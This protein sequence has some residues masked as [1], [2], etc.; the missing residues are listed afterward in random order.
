MLRKLFLHVQPAV[1]QD[2]LRPFLRGEQLN[3]LW[4]YFLHKRPKMLCE[5]RVLRTK[6]DLQRRTVPSIANVIQPFEERLPR[7]TRVSSGVLSRLVCFSLISIALGYAVFNQ[8][9]QP[10]LAWNTSLLIIG[11]GAVF[12]TLAVSRADRRA[13]G[14]LVGWS[15]LLPPAYVGFQ[16]LP[17]PLPV[18]RI[19]SPARAKLIDSLIPITQPPAL[20][21]ISI[22]PAAT[23]V[24][25]LRTLAYSLTVLLI[26]ETSWRWLRRHS[27]APVVPLIVVAAFEGCL[28][29]LQF[30]NGADVAGTYRSHDHFA[31][32][33]EMVLPLTLAY[34]IFLLRKPD[35]AE[36][37]PASNAVKSCIAF[38]CAAVM[39]VGLVYSLSK[40]G[41]LAGLGGLFAIGVLA[42]LSKLKGMVRWFA[43]AGLTVLIALVFVFLPTDQLANAYAGYFSTDPTSMEGRAPIWNDS[44]QLLRAYPAVGTG[45]GTYETAFLK[46]QTAS[47]DWNYTFAHNDYLQLASELGAVGFLIFG[48]LFL[49]VLLKTVRAAF[50]ED[51]NTRLLGLGCVG[52]LTAIGIHSLA[53]FN[54]YI[55]ANALLLS[56]IVGVAISIPSLA[57][58]T[59]SN[60]GARER[61]S[62]RVKVFQSWSRAA[63]RAGPIALGSVLVVYATAW[64]VF[65]TTY[66][67]DPGAER[68]FCN[69]GICGDNIVYAA[70]A[71][72][73]ATPAIV[74]LTNFVEDVKRD[75]AAPH[76]WCDL[77]D[78]F[79][80]AGRLNE[81]RYCFSQAVGL[82][83]EIPPVLLRSANFYHAV[84]DDER[85]LQR[86]A[87]V[88]DKSDVYQS[89]ILDFYRDSGFSV[90]DILSRGLPPGPRAAQTYL[91]YWIQ[92]GDLGK[93]KIAW[94]WTLAHHDADVPTARDYLN[95]LYGN[96]KYQDAA[97]A[98]VRFLGDRRSDYREVNW[99]Y[100]GDFETE[101]SGVPLDWQIARADGPA[102]TT[103][104]SGQSHTG[105]HSLRIRF[106]G[107]ENVNY[108]DTVQK[109]SVPHGT[110]RFSAYIR[111]QGITT[112]KGVAFRIFDAEDSTNL[113]ART[114]Q[115]VGTTP[116]WTRVERTVRVPAATKLLEVQVIREPTLKFD[117]RVSGTAWID[118][119]SLS[120]IE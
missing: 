20:A 81:A 60:N 113:N 44:R 59:R 50:S 48:G 45:L 118:T 10:S 73:S 7:A 11:A 63:L 49:I 110:Y 31:G 67:G 86:G 14:T 108:S 71:T 16:L 41:F 21:A 36:N 109:T 91:R 100:N 117:N 64:M 82:G 74:P 18:L 111:T 76:R 88:L 78:A 83:H 25:F 5:P 98:W 56:W 70:E 38:A 8:G 30:T 26:Y 65:D 52:A 103:I 99:L 35:G 37:L 9:G 42:V 120:R 95:F 34:G 75:P 105:T 27:W 47:V 96:Y 46:Y 93:A 39:L 80:R 92:L 89:S 106:A 40:M 17:L 115:F 57:E 107:T 58:S 101:P 69:F 77:G 33:L 72:K 53:D 19:L 94:D 51:W 84:E 66:K 79:V 23:S 87:H 3:L 24:Y 32:P 90:N 55:P 12:Y 15:V 1:L 29:I 54:L 61:V 43:V 114:E 116:R 13:F 62:A 102:E 97:D 119:V 22:D 104:D 68:A 2:G 6:S 4:E 85:A 112:D 28:G